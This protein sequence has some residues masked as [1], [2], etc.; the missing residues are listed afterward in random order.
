M[1][2]K[3]D[4]RTSDGNTS[5]LVIA[6]F[7]A[8]AGVASAVVAFQFLQHERDV[9]LAAKTRSTIEVLLQHRSRLNEA[10]VG[11]VC[12]DSY[13]KLP[14]EVR[15]SVRKLRGS[16]KQFECVSAW[17]DSYRRCVGKFDDEIPDGSHTRMSDS[18]AWTMGFN[19]GT[20]MESYYWLG[21]LY[22]EDVV[23]RK[24][25]RSFL[26]FEL[27]YDSDVVR[28][29]RSA[30][31]AYNVEANYDCLLRLVAEM[32]HGKEDE[33]RLPRRWLDMCPDEVRYS[34]KT[35]VCT[36]RHKGGVCP[37]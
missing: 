33:G 18:E 9:A 22:S 11:F 3:S 34:R 29:V 2:R 37:N 5:Q 19:I 13:T 31:E 1:L 35:T 6:V 24:V 15:K 23:D 4:K 20:T 7:T 10:E 26:E 30:E 32:D 21:L 25:F 8:V 12:L 28:Y 14:L 36:R 17:C 16:D 27:R